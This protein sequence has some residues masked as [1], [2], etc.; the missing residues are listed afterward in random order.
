MTNGKH[1]HAPK[2]AARKK[3]PAKAKGAGKKTTAAK[4]MTKGMK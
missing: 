4:T 1:P 3:S 2:T